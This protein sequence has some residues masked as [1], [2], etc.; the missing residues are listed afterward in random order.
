MREQNPLRIRLRREA[1][2]CQHV[3]QLVQFG[4]AEETVT[5]DAD[6]TWWA[7]RWP[8]SQSHAAAAAA[9]A[10]ADATAATA[11]STTTTTPKSTGSDAR[12]TDES[13]QSHGQREYNLSI[14]ILILALV[15]AMIDS[16]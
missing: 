11:T 9:A 14:R 4:T 8:E 12:P 15:K 3:P 16:G 2:V 10:A 7:Q 5:A 13:A 6:A 1:G